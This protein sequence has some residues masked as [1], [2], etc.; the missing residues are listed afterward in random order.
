MSDAPLDDLL[1]HAFPIDEGERFVIPEVDDGLVESLLRLP[2]PPPPPRAR[3][4][5]EEG[6]TAPP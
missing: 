4:S 1:T 3:Q 2:E 5:A 6:K